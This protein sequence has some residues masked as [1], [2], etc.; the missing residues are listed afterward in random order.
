M[1]NED[2]FMAIAYLASQRSKDPNTQVGACIVNDRGVVVSVG[3]NQMPKDS[4]KFPWTRDSSK[5]MQ[6]KDP[7]GQ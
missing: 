3:H 1:D 7:Y 4:D 6:K 2:F 5:L